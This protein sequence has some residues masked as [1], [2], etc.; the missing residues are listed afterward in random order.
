[1][2]LRVLFKYTPRRKDAFFL[3]S[4]IMPVFRL[5]MQVATVTCSLVKNKKPKIHRQKVSA[6]LN[7]TMMEIGTRK[8]NGFV[9]DF[10]KH[11]FW[12]EFSE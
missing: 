8:L 3:T 11:W 9:G 10:V 6:D 5:N 1:M 2:M 12:D 4:N 7:G